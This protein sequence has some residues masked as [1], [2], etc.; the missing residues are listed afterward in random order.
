VTKTFTSAAVL[1]LAEQGRV[2][3]DRPIAAYCGRWALC[4]AATVRQTLLHTAGFA[5]P[6]PL[7]WVHLEHE[8]ATFDRRRFVEDILHIQSRSASIPGA[9]YGYSNIGYLLLGELIES[10]SGQSYAQYV[11]QH[12]IAPLRPCDGE[13]LAF[14]VPNRAAHARGALKRF[15]WLNAVLGFMIDRDR[16]V[17]DAAGRHIGKTASDD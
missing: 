4:G 11:A 15:G 2:D 7:S 6:N 12:L 1:K 3:L 9:R 17:D 14:D 5:N 16:L 8:R 13:T 10:V